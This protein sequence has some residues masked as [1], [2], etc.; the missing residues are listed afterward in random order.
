MPMVEQDGII[1]VGCYHSV[2]ACG[3]YY[4]SEVKPT[5][6][7]GHVRLYGRKCNQIADVTSFDAHL[8]FPRGMY[9]YIYIYIST[10]LFQLL[11]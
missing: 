3:L 4:E 5:L 2:I 11:N 6:K 7:S 10:A 1:R 8:N 9:I